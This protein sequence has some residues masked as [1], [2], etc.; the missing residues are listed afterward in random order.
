[1]NLLARLAKLEQVSR[2]YLPEGPY[3]PKEVDDAWAREYER[4]WM[5]Q[6]PRVLRILHASMD[7]QMFVSQLCG[8]PTDFA[9][10][11]ADELDRIAA[12]EAQHDL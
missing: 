10:E 1:M 11:V 4:L 6:M 8:W 7:R 9:N 5:E 12:E 2:P 3:G